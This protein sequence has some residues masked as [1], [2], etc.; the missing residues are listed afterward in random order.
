MLLNKDGIAADNLYTA[1]ADDA[2]LP[3]GPVIVSLTR[4]KA[5]RDQ[6]FAR[7]QKLGV[8]L[9]S[10]ESPETLGSDLE[11]LSLVVLRFPKFRDGRPFSWA[12]ML[13][14]RLGY[15]GE[16]RASGDYLY[17]QIAFLARVGVDAFELPPG[18]TPALF[19]RALGEMT[20]VYQ[21]AADDKKTIRDL[22]A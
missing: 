8:I 1:V 7:N 19:Q 18:V 20:N 15:T 9:T 17:D 5:E 4:L 12:R 16:V 2:A 3:D 10:A 22:R 14:T 21:P 11:R 6:L 13:R